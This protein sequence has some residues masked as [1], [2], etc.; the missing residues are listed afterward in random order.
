MA[1]P[2]ETFVDTGPLA[3]DAVK[4]LISRGVLQVTKLDGKLKVDRIALD[5][6]IKDSTHYLS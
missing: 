1:A 2:C 4:K 6:L 5:R 3:P